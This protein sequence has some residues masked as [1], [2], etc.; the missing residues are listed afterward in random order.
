MIT[1]YPS[2]FSPK[3]VD[4]RIDD[5]NAGWKGRVLWSTSGAWQANSAKGRTFSIPPESGDNG[6]VVWTKSS[7]RQVS[8]APASGLYFWRSYS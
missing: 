5:P 2:G 4:G 8:P 1:G 3:N 6:H 7:C